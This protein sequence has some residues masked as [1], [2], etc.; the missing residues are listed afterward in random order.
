MSPLLAFTL[1]FGSGLLFVA[2]ALVGF[3]CFVI[4]RRA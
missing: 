1:G 2:A 4:G 3:V